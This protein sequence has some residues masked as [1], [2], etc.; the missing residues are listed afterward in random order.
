MYGP[1]AV[2]Q[3]EVERWPVGRVRVGEV[4]LAFGDKRGE[5]GDRLPE[6][7]AERPGVC[8]GKVPG[9][10]A[11]LGDQHPCPLSGRHRCPPTEGPDK[12]LR[13]GDG[14]E[15]PRREAP[16]WERHPWQRVER[17]P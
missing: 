4:A 12:R 15:A 3:H 5:V 17:I 1:G 8:A 14:R 6:C 10:L 13:K 7:D 11:N 16:H 9:S 2:E